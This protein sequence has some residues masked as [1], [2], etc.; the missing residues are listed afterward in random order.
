MQPALL[1]K[2]LISLVAAAF[3]GQLVLQQPG[4]EPQTLGPGT[5]DRLR[6]LPTL[7]LELA[8]RFAQP[9]ASPSSADPLGIKLP[10][11]LVG[12]RG[13]RI[14]FTGLCLFTRKLALKPRAPTGLSLK[15]RRQLVTARFTVLLVLSI[16]GRDRLGD[17][18]SC[19]PIIV[20]VR[21]AARTRGQLRA[22]DG[23]GT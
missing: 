3:R 15:L 14:V 8:V 1:A 16:I 11:H 18:L 9:A 17:D 13:R 5:R 7:G 2:V 6:V 23:D 22:V 12:P 4:A 20:N 21:V 10:N 19:D